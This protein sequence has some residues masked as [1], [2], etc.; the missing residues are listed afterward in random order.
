[1]LDLTQAVII[2]VALSLTSM[3]LLI[4]YQIIMIL[5]SVRVSLGK[6]NQILD[7]ATRVSESV[8]EP[9]INISGFISGLKGGAQLISL[10]TKK[11][12]K[13]SDEE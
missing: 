11:K 10:F 4:G 12:A 13:P 6:T 9:I 7:D 3:L 8:A 2:L 1:M 5:K